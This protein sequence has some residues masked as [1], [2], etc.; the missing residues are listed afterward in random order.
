M[1]EEFYHEIKEIIIEWIDNNY[2][3]YQNIFGDDDK[4]HITKEELAKKELEY[5]KSKDSWGS[6]YTIT[7]SC[8]L[9]NLNIAVYD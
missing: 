1:D 5:I 2:E 4:N 7:I 3:R 8:L 6:D 9:F